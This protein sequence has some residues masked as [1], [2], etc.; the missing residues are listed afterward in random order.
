[1][2]EHL[3]W[4]RTRGRHCLDFYTTSIKKKLRPRGPSIKKSG[5]CAILA[6]FKPQVLSLGFRKPWKAGTSYRPSPP[7]VDHGLHVWRQRAFLIVSIFVSKPTSRQTREEGEEKKRQAIVNNKYKRSRFLFRVSRERKEKHQG[8]SIL[9]TGIPLCLIVAPSA[10][11]VQVATPSIVT[12]APS[13]TG[14]SL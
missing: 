9:G 1:M 14:M 2:T 11:S 4:K 8:G 13:Q 5:N 6:R 3:S 7:T 10:V 12:P